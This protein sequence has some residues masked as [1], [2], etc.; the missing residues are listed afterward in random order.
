MGPS[1]VSR[2]SALRMAGFALA[3][4]CFHPQIEPAYALKPGTPSKE[5]LLNKIR[6][7]RTPEQI[8]AAKERVAE[9]RRI[10]LEKQR[11]LQ[12]AADRRKAG[13]EEDTTK[14]TEIESSLRGQ[15]YFPTARK[16]Y[17]PRVKLAYESISGME[18]AAR[19]SDWRSVKELSEVLEDAALPLKLYASSLGGGGLNINSKF[20]EAMTKQATSYEKDMRKL[21]GA[22]KKKENSVVLKVLNDM[23]S[24]IDKYRQL[25][26]LEAP[27]FGIGEIPTESKVGS[28]FG[29][30]NSALYKRNKA[31]QSADNTRAN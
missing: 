15:Y 10:R 13:L 6:D 28:G 14:G 12:A 5:S 27:D 7:E 3:S 25:G 1:P 29:N 21:T 31:V 18:N 24:S 17:L 23:K 4:V 8:Q 30:N 20:I 2:R 26:R 11:E 19:G 22:I 16:R 9:E